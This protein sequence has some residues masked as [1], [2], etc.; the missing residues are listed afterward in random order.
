MIRLAVMLLLGAGAPLAGAAVE[1]PAITGGEV[2]VQGRVTV[3]CTRID[4][5]PWCRATRWIDATPG[6]VEVVLRDFAHHPDVF[7]RVA[8]CRVLAPDVV[9]TRFD[10]PFPLDDRDQVVR[11]QVLDE[12]PARVFRWQAVE[13][14]AAPPVPGVVRLVRTRGE[15]R[16]EPS[17]NGTR[18]STTWLADLGGDMPDWMQRRARALQGTESLEWLA[19]AVEGR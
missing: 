7:P 13:H 15:W 12:P 4:G 8:A 18:V 11:Y 16:L 5:A 1:V 14:P 6:A 10:Y 9:Y 19:R 2:L 17:G 3:V